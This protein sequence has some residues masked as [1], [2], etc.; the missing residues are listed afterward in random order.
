M[1][2]WLANAFV[3]VTLACCVL[4]VSVWVRSASGPIREE[5]GHTWLRDEPPTAGREVLRLENGVLS[6]WFHRVHY[7]GPSEAIRLFLQFRRE[8]EHPGWTYSYDYAQH[9][10]TTPERFRPTAG[11]MTLNGPAGTVLSWSGSTHWVTVPL[12][13]LV[14]LFAIPAIVRALG[15]LRR[16][17]RIAANLCPTCGYDL[18]AT[19]DPAG[20][21]LPRCPECGTI[22]AAPVNP[23]IAS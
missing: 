19:P 1:R 11:A 22:S 12:W 2:R 7:A 10:Q 20:G 18:R 6:V 15:D 3:A 8:E 14:L 23:Q 13:L 5:V 9:Q 4:S 16:R 21:L 17:R